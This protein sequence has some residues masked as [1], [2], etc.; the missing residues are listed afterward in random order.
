FY[1]AAAPPNLP[2]S[3]SIPDKLPHRAVVEVLQLRDLIFGRT[4]PRVRAYQIRI[5]RM[6]RPVTTDE[7]GQREAKKREEL[8]VD[9]QNLPCAAV[10]SRLYRRPHAP[11]CFACPRR[12]ARLHRQRQNCAARAR[13]M[14]PPNSRCID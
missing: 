3:L 7:E 11:A 10:L 2:L 5:R 6:T 13:N 9:H 14:A 1:E 8:D 4:P 12:N